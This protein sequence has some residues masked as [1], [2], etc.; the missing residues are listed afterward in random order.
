MVA[1]VAALAGAASPTMADSLTFIKDSNVWLANPDGSGLY[2]VTLDGTAGAP[3]ETPSQA[4]DGTVVAIRQT[5]GQRRQIY[6]MT[7]SGALLNAPINTPAPG[8]GAIDGKVS[9]DGALVAYWFVTTVSDP[10]CPFCV[11]ISNRVLLSYSDRFTGADEVGTPNTGGWPSWLSNDTITLGSG[12]ATQWYYKLG[13]PAAAEWFTDFDVTGEI[14][15]LLD[16]E[17]A[18]SGDRLAVVRGDNQETILVLKMNGPPPSKPTIAN[19]SCAALSGP[20]G[21]FVDPTW[22]ADGT[23][24]AWQEDDGVWTMSVPADLADCAGFGTPALRVAGARNPDLGPAAINPGPR[25]PCGNPGN[26]AACPAPAPGPSPGPCCAPGPT[27]CCAPGPTQTL[28]ERLNALLS[29][30]IAA[31]RRLGIRGLLRKRQFQVTFDAPEPG[32]LGVRLT[33]ARRAARS[34]A[35]SR[36]TTLATGSH[37]FTRS[38]RATFKV[39]LT[40]RGAKLLRRSRRLRVTLSC[41]FKPKTG[42]VVS[43]KRSVA[44]R[45]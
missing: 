6:R 28:R 18:P 23:L 20:T 31:L 45:R 25:P 41:S 19:G 32:T 1:V 9:P 15:S 33:A 36:V 42:S 30:Q 40:R 10:L 5:P 8:T 27:P 26:P 21:K 17:A 11:N 43:V 29:R 3:Y 39:K 35:A 12:S 13:M 24:L 22:A 4:N 14:K 2:Q 37:I 38:G 7:Q 16:A 44:L 34:A